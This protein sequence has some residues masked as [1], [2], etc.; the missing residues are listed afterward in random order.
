MHTGVTDYV[1]RSQ[2]NTVV[3]FNNAVRRSC[4]NIQIVEDSLFENDEQ[5][6]L[7][8]INL[9]G[10]FARPDLFLLGQST[11]ITIQDNDGENTYKL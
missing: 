9:S 3:T 6:S 2:F 1:P 8:L 10:D 4:V 5:F 11:T 7:Q